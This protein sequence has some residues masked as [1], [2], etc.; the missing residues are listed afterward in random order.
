MKVKIS[1]EYR[2]CYVDGK[3][4]LFHKWN[5]IAVVQ[6]PGFAVGSSPGGQLK[7]TFGLVE[8]EDGTVRE[9]SP[10]KIKFADR[11]IKEYYFDGESAKDE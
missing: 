6:A 10:H 2:P 7:E 1:I 9:V 11:K 5:D 3:K 8:F 4:A